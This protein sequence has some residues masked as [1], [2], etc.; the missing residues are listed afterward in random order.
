MKI[1][2]GFVLRQLLGEHVV[3]GEGLERVN[4]NKI[5]SL[6]STAAYLFEQV[7]D[8]DFDIRMMADLLLEKYEVTEET[9]LADSQKLADSWREAG[10]LEE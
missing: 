5:I 9:A 2:K 4:F 1:K 3:T 10:L 8:K 7:K 6:N